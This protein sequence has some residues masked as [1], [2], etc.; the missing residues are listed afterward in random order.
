MGEITLTSDC[1]P[2]RRVEVTLC[3]KIRENTCF[4]A[5]NGYRFT[6]VNSYFV[7]STCNKLGEIYNYDVEYEYAIDI[8]YKQD[9]KSIYMNY[10][11]TLL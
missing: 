3:L 4:I 8:I 9:L 10:N 1:I 7:W 5:R 11:S 2:C 6:T